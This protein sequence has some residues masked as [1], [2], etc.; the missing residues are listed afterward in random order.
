M[1]INEEESA[2]LSLENMELKLSMVLSLMMPTRRAGA[3]TRAQI[4]HELPA[5]CSGPARERGLA[6]LKA[7]PGKGLGNLGRN[8]GSPP[9][10]V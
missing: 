2:L 1:R 5:T 6:L 4:P 7:N 3:R 10:C 9:S 8:L